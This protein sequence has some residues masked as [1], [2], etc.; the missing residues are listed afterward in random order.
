MEYRF[1]CRGLCK[2]QT[3][4]LG[5]ASFDEIVIAI[6]KGGRHKSRDNF[7]NPLRCN[8]E[9]EKY[10]AYTTSVLFSL[11]NC[12]ITVHCNSHST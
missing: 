1:E 4:E 3:E 10:F 9:D 7:V 12:C 6:Q 5:G 11:D 8:R 2:I